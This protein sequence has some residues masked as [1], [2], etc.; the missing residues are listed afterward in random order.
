[1]QAYAFVQNEEPRRNVMLD[2]ISQEKTA[3]AVNHGAEKKRPDDTEKDKRRCDYYFKISL[4]IAWTSYTRAWRKGWYQNQF[5]LILMVHPRILSL[6]Q[7]ELAEVFP[8][9][10]C[11]LSNVWRLNM[12]PSRISSLLL[13]CSRVYLQMPLVLLTLSFLDHWFRATDH[14][15]WYHNLSSSYSTSSGKD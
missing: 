13:L 11:K 7:M 1:M 5:M 14:L 15:T 10:R 3:L 4:E 9:K 8:W 2:T 12:K 6:L